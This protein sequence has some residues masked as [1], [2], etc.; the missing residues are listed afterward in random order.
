MYDLNELIS[1]TSHKKKLFTAYQ[2]KTNFLT[3][4]IRNSHRETLSEHLISKIIPFSIIFSVLCGILSLIFTKSPTCALDA[5]NI[6][7]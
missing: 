6:S 7:S 1:P 5:I 4:F 3:N 2:Y